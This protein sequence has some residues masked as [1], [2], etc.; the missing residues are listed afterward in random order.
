[1]NK[2]VVFVAYDTA[3]KL[4]IGRLGTVPLGLY[5]RAS[6]LVG[7]PIS[8][9]QSALFNVAFSA[10]SRLQSEP[11]RQAAAFLRG[12]SV[13]VSLTLPLM[14]VCLVFPGEVVTTLLG[15]KWGECVPI[16]QML[17]P[18]QIVASIMNPMGW[19]LFSAGLARRS[20]LM[21]FV[22]SPTVILGMA[23]GKM[24]GPF[25]VATGYSAAMLAL[26]F[27]LTTWAIHGTGIRVRDFWRTLSMPLLSGLVAGGVGVAVKHLG[28]I[29]YIISC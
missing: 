10:L 4:I 23:I 15:P 14:V 27:P 17:V 16:F 24:W 25:G 12:L 18:A 5:N 21:A 6:S 19:L 7:M 3:D 9:L 22:I 13:A 2:I 28:R 29:T 11:A 20:L 1:M 8:Q 26:L